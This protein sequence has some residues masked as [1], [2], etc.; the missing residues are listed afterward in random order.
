MRVPRLVCSGETAELR[1]DARTSYDLVPFAPAVRMDVLRS[2]H[3]R[4]DAADYRAVKIAWLDAQ[5][6]QL[7][8]ASLR[9]GPA[10]TRRC[11]D[12]LLRALPALHGGATPAVR[13]RREGRG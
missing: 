8:A 13:L 10:E 3:G 4:L 7:V 2:A 6:L 11:A 5:R 9:A 12:A 1:R